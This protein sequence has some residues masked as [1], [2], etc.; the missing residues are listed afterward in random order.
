VT[1]FLCNLDLFRNQKTV[2]LIWRKFQPLHQCTT[3]WR[4]PDVL[5]LTLL[6]YLLQDLHI[7]ICAIEWWQFIVT[8][9]V[10]VLWTSIFHL[11]IIKSVNSNFTLAVH[12]DRP[13]LTFCLILRKKRKNMA[14]LGFEPTISRS[15]VGCVNHYSIGILF[16]IQQ[17]YLSNIHCDETKI[18]SWHDWVLVSALPE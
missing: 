14:T 3:M 9:W 15:E 4:K 16:V 8:L 7:V 6:K 12:S 5:G 1:W 10:L 13:R 2:Y 18:E 17:I 11:L